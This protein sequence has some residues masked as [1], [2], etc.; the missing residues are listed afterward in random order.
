MCIRDSIRAILK[1]RRKRVSFKNVPS[2]IEPKSSKSIFNIPQRLILKGFAD[3][4]GTNTRFNFTVHA[5]VFT[6][7]LHMPTTLH[8]PTIKVPP[9]NLRIRSYNVKGRL[10][11]GSV[12]L[13]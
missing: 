4:F 2:K 1:R 11:L 6:G 13:R 3:A 7:A 12:E 8:T 5:G 10:S 9:Y